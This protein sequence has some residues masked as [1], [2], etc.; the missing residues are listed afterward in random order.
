MTIGGRPPLIQRRTMSDR[1]SR[2]VAVVITPAFDR[3]IPD[4]WS[5]GQGCGQL[6]TRSRSIA[7]CFPPAR[8]CK[9]GPVIHRAHS[10]RRL[11]AATV[12]GG[13]LVGAAAGCTSEPDRPSLRSA[14]AADLRT[15]AT[16]T[17]TAVSITP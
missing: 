16:A 8:P 12:A 9:A 2:G 7:V 10:V 4:R 14:G 11:L 15:G 17:S 3:I 5:P 1:P 13:L 6:P